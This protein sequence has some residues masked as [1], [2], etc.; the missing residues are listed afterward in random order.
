MYHS[1]D[2]IK[3]V[4]KQIISNRRVFI[5]VSTQIQIT[6]GYIWIFYESNDSNTHQDLSLYSEEEPKH[7]GSKWV[8]ANI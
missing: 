3:P 8:M 6:I 4:S 1:Y 5:P 7:Q 2:V